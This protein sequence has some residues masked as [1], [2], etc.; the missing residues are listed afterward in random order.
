MFLMSTSDRYHHG[1]LRTALLDAAE[2]IV[3]AEGSP[4]FSLRELA[5]AAGVS[6][7]APYKHFADRSALLSAL[8]ARWLAEFVD[9]QRAAATGDPRQA[10]LAAGTAYVQWAR[11]HPPRYALMFDPALNRGP[12]D[13]GAVGLEAARHRELLRALVADASRVGVIHDPPEVAGPRLWATVHGLA[14]LVI[15]GHLPESAVSAVLEASLAAP[16]SA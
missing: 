13:P 3:D 4:A 9:G 10:L 16:T 8:A 14:A 5:R 12:E 6:H 7:A 11:R 15:L 2:R 1:S